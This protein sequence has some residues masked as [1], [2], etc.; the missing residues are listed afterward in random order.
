MS[1]D[2]PEPT[3]QRSQED[4]LTLVRNLNKEPLTEFIIN[5]MT[6][7]KAQI[8]YVSHSIDEKNIIIDVGMSQPS[9]V[10]EKDL[11][12]KTVRWTE[13]KRTGNYEIEVI[14]KY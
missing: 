1:W 4:Y 12:R 8:E 11:F 13:S 9:I 5:L 2:I 14:K 7:F 6:N 3:P 10:Y